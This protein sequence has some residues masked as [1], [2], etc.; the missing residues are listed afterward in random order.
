[1]IGNKKQDDTAINSVS[2]FFY[3]FRLH[4]LELRFQFG[5]LRKMTSNAQTKTRP[6]CCFLAFSGIKNRVG[7]L[8]FF[9]PNFGNLAFFPCCWLQNLSLAF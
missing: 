5:D 4:V 6:S 3:D 7:N 9:K 1:M 2:Y 8:A